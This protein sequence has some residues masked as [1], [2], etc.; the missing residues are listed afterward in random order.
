[1]RTI[2]L[3]ILHCSAT[4]EDKRFTF[5]QCRMDHIRHRGWKDIGYHF[6]IRLDG[7]IELGRPIAEV[8]AHCAGHNAESI[9]ICYV[10]GMKASPQPS[11]GGRGPI[12]SDAGPE[13][14]S[15]LL[16]PNTSLNEGHSSLLIPNSSLT[17][18][19]TRTPE[20]KAAMA[21]L[22]RVLHRMFP[23]ATVHG[24]REYARKACPCFDV[25]ELKLQD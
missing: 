5:D 17:A 18:A 2:T 13:G 15:S 14:H 4:R 12:V 8:G 10:G 3:I 20:Q 24:H 11:P 16:I 19:D 7:T 22:L 25:A 23:E 21:E 9:G 6:V 1:M